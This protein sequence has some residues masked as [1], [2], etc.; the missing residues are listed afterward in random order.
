M[1]GLFAILSMVTPESDAQ[2]RIICK[3]D[4]KINKKMRNRIK[5][6]K[7]CKDV[8]LYYFNLLK[9]YLAFRYIQYNKWKNLNKRQLIKF[10]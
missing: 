4:D 3:L 7:I 2:L 5:L 9:T 6:W 8:N 1:S 10:V